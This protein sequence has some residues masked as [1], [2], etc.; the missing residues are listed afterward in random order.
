MRLLLD[1]HTLLWWANNDAQLSSVAR[2]H[3]QHARNHVLVS[4]ASVWE[5]AVKY[6]NGRLP[7]AQKF[8][9]EVPEYLRL[10]NFEALPITLEHALRAG[11]LPGP[12]RD[13]FDRM[14]IAQALQENLAL[15]S[16]DQAL[17]GYGAQRV[18]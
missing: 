2:A 6:R 7:S 18:W 8:V 5:I 17:D 3:I 1:T 4:S 13:P 11:L 12:H 10:Q 15:I 9:S 16:N 14:L